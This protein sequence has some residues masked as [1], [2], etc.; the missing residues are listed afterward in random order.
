MRSSRQGAIPS[1]LGWLIDELDS[2]AERLRTLEAP[3]GESLQNT[4]AKLQALVENIQAE[5]DAYNAA[6]WTND[7]IDARIYAIVGSILSGNVTIGGNLNVLGTAAF[8]GARGTS[9]VSAPNRVSAWL[10]GPG[11]ARLGHT[12]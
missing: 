7:Q 12:A 2:F 6:R 4:V 1:E 9:L 5:L 3:S 10:A 8:P 11:D